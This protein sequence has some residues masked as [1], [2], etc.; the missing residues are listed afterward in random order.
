MTQVPRNLFQRCI[1]KMQSFSTRLTPV[2]IVLLM[3]LFCFIL[4]LK[5]DCFSFIWHHKHS[6]LSREKIGAADS[7]WIQEMHRWSAAKGKYSQGAQD[8]YLERI[9]TKIGITNKYFVEFGFNEASY[10]SGGS[11]A[12]TRALHRLGWRGLL[13]DATNENAHINLQKHFLYAN[14]V[15]RIFM[16]NHVPEDLDYLSCDMDSHDLWIF[17]EILK[18]GFRPRVITTEFNSNYPLTL[19]ISLID[20]SILWNGTVPKNFPFMSP[21]SCAWGFLSDFE[22]FTFQVGCEVK[23]ALTWK[24]EAACKI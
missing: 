8:I 9:F 22:N 18:A 16:S 1:S 21:L 17:R 12:N 7:D 10:D 15:A 4:H 19:S 20:P 3:G 2:F 24:T 6:S 13:L 11:G 14:N 5:T 23:I